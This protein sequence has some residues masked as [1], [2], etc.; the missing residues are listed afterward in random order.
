MKT[1]KIRF[2][3]TACKKFDKVLDVDINEHGFFEIP[4]AICPECLFVLD[5]VIDHHKKDG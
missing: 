1:I 2:R 5:Q 4:N 3:C